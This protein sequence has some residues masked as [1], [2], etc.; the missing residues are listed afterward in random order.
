MSSAALKRPSVTYDDVARQCC[1]AGSSAAGGTSVKQRIRIGMV[2]GG[3]GAWVGGPHRVAMRIDDR[4]DLV[5]GAFSRDFERS[6]S[7]GEELGIDP[8]RVYPSYKDMAPAE[9]ERS[10]GIE[11]VSIVTHHN[12]H[13]EIAVAFLDKGFHVVCE[14]PVTL[15]LRDALD[16]HRRTQQAGLVFG[17]THN[18]SAYPMVR[19]AARMVRDGVIGEVRVAHAEHAQGSGASARENEDDAHM[20][21]HTDPAIVTTASVVYNLGTHAHHLLRFVSDLEVDEVS[22]EM[23]THVPG[24]R[25]YDDAFANLRLSNGARGTVWASMVAAGNE[26]GLRIRIF[27]EKGS[28]EWRHEDPQHLVLRPIDGPEQLFSPGR[29][30]LSEDAHRAARLGRGHSEGF[31][32]SFANLYR[33]IADAIEARRSGVPAQVRELSFPTIRD[34]VLGVRFVEAV[35]ESHGKGGAWVDATVAN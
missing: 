12:T 34:G 24:R 22:A 25:V 4:Y 1:G 18:Y 20:A 3:P 14:K 35:A 11:A 33:E 27:G 5:A 16:L 19:Q 9:A 17:L 23:T 31:F 21:W 7:M 10:D 13:H 26:H 2:G 28:L 32:E 30:G 15:T 29:A 8:D 6:K